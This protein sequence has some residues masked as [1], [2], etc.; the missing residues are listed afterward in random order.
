[1]LEGSMLVRYAY[2]GKGANS[3]SSDPFQKKCH[4]T[5]LRHAVEIGIELKRNYGNRL[6]YVDVV[7][8]IIDTTLV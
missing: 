1:M 6:I 3:S 7:V 4:A 8:R 2:W 5:S